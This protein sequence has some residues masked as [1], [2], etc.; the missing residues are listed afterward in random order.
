ML[1]LEEGEPTDP[2]AF[3]TMVPNWTVGETFTADSGERPV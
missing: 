3:V 1:M 2:A